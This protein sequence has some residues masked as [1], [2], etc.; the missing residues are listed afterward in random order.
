MRQNAVILD[1]K[2]SRRLSGQSAFDLGGGTGPSDFTTVPR[3]VNYNSLLVKPTD[4]PKQ[5]LPL[6][7]G[8][9]TQV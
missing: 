7:A 1:K 6:A 2:R 8:I 9:R 3:A 5:V 4:P